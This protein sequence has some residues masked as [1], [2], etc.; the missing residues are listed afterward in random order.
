[1]TS[2]LLAERELIPTRLFMAKKMV[3]TSR[4]TEVYWEIVCSYAQAQMRA[5]R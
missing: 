2:S 3:M 5:E 4:L 1:M